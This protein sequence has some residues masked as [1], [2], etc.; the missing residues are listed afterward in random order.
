MTLFK[1][2]DRPQ[3]VTIDRVE[4]VLTHNNLDYT[5][6]EDGI[7]ATVDG[8][9]LRVT[10][11]N[12]KALNFDFRFFDMPLPQESLPEAQ[13]WAQE[14]NLDATIGTFCIGVHND[15]EVY[16]SSQHA[17]LITQ[18]ATDEQLAEFFRVGIEA[19]VDNLEDFVEEFGLE[20]PRRR[21]K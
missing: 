7:T 16:A 2:V 12:G 1:E 6:R 13:R 3:P 8:F 19:Q 18:G 21:G 5:R 17:F 11:P 15:G 20:R 9:F 14:R 4:R 10:I